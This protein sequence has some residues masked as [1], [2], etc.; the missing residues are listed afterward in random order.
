MEEHPAVPAGRTE[1]RTAGTGKTENAKGAGNADRT[2]KTGEADGPRASGFTTAVLYTALVIVVVLTGVLAAIAVLMTTNPDALPGAERPR[3]LAVP[4]YFAPIIRSQ[5]APCPG[6]RAALDRTGSTCYEVGAGVEVTAVHT[7][8]T[9]PEKDGTYAVR[10][11]LPSPF[12]ER[13]S[14]LTRET[15]DKQ[16]AI[17]A[18]QKLVATPTVT[19]PITVDSLSIAGGFSKQTADTLVAELLGT[20]TPQPTTGVPSTGPS[21]PQDPGTGNPGMD[22]PGTG[23]P[24]TGGLG[25]ENPPATGL[26]DSST[27]PALQPF[28]G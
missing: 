23:D 17:L 9:V 12:R 15:V 21:G 26:P 11:A 14:D 16:I 7:I 25:T 13:V 22:S 20:A 24:G 1:E 10:V 4:I 18:G 2:D 5:P 8:E 27:G 19:Q 28:G 3:K 6:V